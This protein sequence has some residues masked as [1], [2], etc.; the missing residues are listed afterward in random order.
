MTNEEGAVGSGNSDTDNS[1]DV[2]GGCPVCGG[3]DG[4]VNV[5]RAHWFMCDKH[6]TK[7]CVGD[8]WF[9]CW[10][11]ETEEIWRENARLLSAYRTVKPEF[12]LP[13][14]E[15]AAGRGDFTEG[16]SLR[17]GPSAEALIANGRLIN[18]T[19]VALSAG[20]GY[21]TAIT[22]PVWEACIKEPGLVSGDTQEDRLW[23]LLHSILVTQ[24]NEAPES[25]EVT[26]NIVGNVG[27]R[28]VSLPTRLV[29]VLLADEEIPFVTPCRDEAD[30]GKAGISDDVLAAIETI[31]DYLW[32]DEAKDWQAAD[33]E[34]RKRH[35]FHSLRT[36]RNWL[37]D[38]T[39]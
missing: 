20:L 19:R 31:V 13:E 25:D 17:L 7:W 11:F 26:W 4:F 2:C 6:K 3:N 12:P 27:V 21:R 37:D 28:A 32:D 29:T 35:I 24:K 16:E 10:R 8:N 22:H 39:Q 33:T 18:V 36:V 15:R 5:G 9:R 30:G 1:P 14:K 38:G 34:C 23:T